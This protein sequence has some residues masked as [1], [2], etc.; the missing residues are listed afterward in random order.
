M[1][2]VGVAGL[3]KMGSAIACNLLDH[4]YSVSVWNRTTATAE[5]LASAGAVV[6][7]DI[8]SLVS[9]VDAVIAMLW[10]DAVAREVTLS[11]IIPA[12]K[13][14]QLVV[15]SSTLSPQM[16]EMLAQAAAQ[17]EIDFLACP[18]IGSITEARAGALITL[19]GGTQQAYDRANLLL[20]AMASTVTYT[21][22]PLASGYVKL[23]SNSVLGIIAEAAGE[24]LRVSDRAGVDRAL[25][26]EMI[27]H[28]F[29]RAPGK[30]EQLLE[31]DSKPR[32]SVGAL[33]K[34]LRL[35]E[36]AY[37]K[38]DAPAPILDC[39]LPSFERAVGAG[40]SD[41]DYIA[42]AL[43]IEESGLPAR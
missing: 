16:Y 30:K 18:V 38:V 7:P 25:A 13:K 21:G 26:I 29:A 14:G 10:D 40:L 24:L 5:E 4:G 19:P 27:L 11:Q 36:A 3:G 43:A 37:A 31:R 8:A 35:A 41:A 15:E 20:E 28:A 9:G 22:S 6:C 2:R 17:R 34:D 42:V 12:A 33:L 1:K 32:F 23:A 39:V